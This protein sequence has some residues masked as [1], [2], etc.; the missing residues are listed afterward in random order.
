MNPAPRAFR[1]TTRGFTDEEKS[2]LRSL[3]GLLRPYLRGE[4]S[5]VEHDS[6]HLCLVRLDAPEPV[7]APG[8]RWIGCALRPREF[9]AGTLHRP[10]RAAQ[11]LNALNDAVETDTARQDV[12]AP[13][14]VANPAAVP[15]AAMS[16]RLRLVGWPLDFDRG[17]SDRIHMLA[18]MT[19][20]PL[21][22]D[23]LAD[24]TSVARGTL[25]GWL[26]ELHDAGLVACDQLATQ[27]VAPAPA[28]LGWRALI[29]RVGHRLG[30]S[31]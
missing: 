30:F 14:P 20:G 23:E 22:F 15:Q 8:G 18:A 12:P 3:L 21:H 26:Q 9:A 19:A 1:L 31:L 4:W 27:D 11:I 6:A 28:S 13:A 2:S 29:A 5:L 10:L 24:R 16:G 25:R 17:P 7:E